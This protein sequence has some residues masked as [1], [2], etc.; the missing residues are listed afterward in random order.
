[1]KNSSVGALL[2]EI[3]LSSPGLLGAETGR[4]GYGRTSLESRDLR[5]HD[6]M[7]HE[8]VVHKTSISLKKRDISKNNVMEK[9]EWNPWIE[10]LILGE[11]RGACALLYTLWMHVA[12]LQGGLGMSFSLLA[13]QQIHNI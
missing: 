9:L 13:L 10:T 8:Q 4:L 11:G 2:Q 5:G 12:P 3:P 7:L 6:V 1:M